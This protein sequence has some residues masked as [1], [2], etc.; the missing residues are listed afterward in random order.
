[1]YAYL[2]KSNEYDYIRVIKNNS[3]NEKESI[4]L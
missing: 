1:M 2:F 3:E 4:T